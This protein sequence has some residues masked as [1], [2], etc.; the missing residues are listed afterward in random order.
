MININDRCKLE[1]GE[2]DKNPRT[3][4]VKRKTQRGIVMTE[5]APTR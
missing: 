1:K 2:E 3:T 4:I 5:Q